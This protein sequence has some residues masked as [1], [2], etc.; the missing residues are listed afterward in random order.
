MVLGDQADSVLSDRLGQALQEL[1]IARQAFRS[2]RN[3]V[4]REC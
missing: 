4:E 1:P 2:T 3:Y